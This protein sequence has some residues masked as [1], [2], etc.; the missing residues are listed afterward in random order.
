MEGVGAMNLQQGIRGRCLVSQKS[1]HL[2]DHIERDNIKTPGYR[3]LRTV[4]TQAMRQTHQRARQSATITS[5]AKEE[6]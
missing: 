4:Q 6:S 2:N 5:S 1:T 3:N